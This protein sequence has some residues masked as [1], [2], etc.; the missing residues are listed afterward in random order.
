[1]GAGWCQAAYSNE[2][3][4]PAAPILLPGGFQADATVPPEPVNWNPDNFQQVW[5]TIGGQ[6]VG[7]TNPDVCLNVDDQIS[8]AEK[9]GATGI[10]FDME[11]C[12]DPAT[13]PDILS[14]I[15]TFVDAVKSTKPDYKFVYVPQGGAAVATP[16]DQAAFFDYVAPMQYG[17]TDSYQVESQ[18]YSWDQ[19]QGYIQN[20]VDA[21]WTPDMMFLTY[22]SASAAAE[23]N[24]PEVLTKLCTMAKEQGYAG[25]L[26]WPSG[27]KE[28]DSH[29]TGKL[30]TCS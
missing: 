18:G 1:M 14:E 26:G 16:K 29:N 25:L 6:G 10:N 20:W 24:G 2:C 28:T 4:W 23:P 27:D 5:L 19:I 8:Y 15:G 7:V 12:L 11:G 22:Q 3:T 9:I 30:A 17:G 13:N 21:G